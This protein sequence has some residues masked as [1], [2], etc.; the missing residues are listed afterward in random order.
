VSLDL[1]LCGTDVQYTRQKGEKLFLCLNT[2]QSHFGGEGKGGSKAPRIIDFDA[3]WKQGSASRSGSFTPGLRNLRYPLDRMINGPQRRSGRGGLKK[4]PFAW[5]E[6]NSSLPVR[7]QPLY[8]LSYLEIINKILEELVANAVRKWRGH[9][10]REDDILAFKGLKVIL[11]WR[12]HRHTTWRRKLSSVI[13]N[14][15]YQ[16]HEAVRQ[17]A[18]AGNNKMTWNL[19]YIILNL[20]TFGS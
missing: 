16:L 13:I 15:H 5:R 2:A 6:S 11:L 20:V 19:C 9:T 18:E 10:E 1:S 4:T 7:R 17:G 12:C 8:W 14:L 3:R